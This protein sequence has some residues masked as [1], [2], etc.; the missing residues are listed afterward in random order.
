M[1]SIVSIRDEIKEYIRSMEMIDH[2]IS[3][4]D[5]KVLDEF[6]ERSSGRVIENLLVRLSSI[7]KD[8]KRQLDFGKSFVPKKKF[9]ISSPAVKFPNSFHE[10]EVLYY[11]EGKYLEKFSEYGFDEIG[12][13]NPRIVSSLSTIGDDLYLQY[14]SQDRDKFFKDSSFTYGLEVDVDLRQLK[15]NKQLIKT[16]KPMGVTH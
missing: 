1:G 16:T 4:E 2:E 15:K 14:T 9:K 11:L 8:D 3:A 12:I 7:L 6:F 13:S 5:K 10:H